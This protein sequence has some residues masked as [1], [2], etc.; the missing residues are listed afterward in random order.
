MIIIIKKLINSYGFL[1]N[2]SADL[3]PSI[4]QEKETIIQTNEINLEDNP[5]PRI[6]KNSYSF[7][8]FE[9]LKFELCKN[10]RT[11]LADYSFI[12]RRLQKDNLIYN[13]INEKT[14]RDFLFDKYQI[15]LD[16]LKIL[17]YCSTLNKE[18]LYNLLK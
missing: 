6:F 4:I 9:K 3:N 12:F 5:Y 16:K 13:D 11:N 1:I 14:F 18:S 8:L 7:G 17:E 2:K 10:E 15:N